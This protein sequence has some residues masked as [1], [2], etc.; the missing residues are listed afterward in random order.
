[1]V[2]AI[3]LAGTHADKSKLIYGQ[4]KAF[5]EI[6]NKPIIL[7]VLQA[8]QNSDYVDKI[9]VVG[10]REKLEKIIDP[11]TIDILDESLAPTES[12]RF[13]ENAV[14][15]Y[16][17]I[18]NKYNKKRIVIAPGDLFCATP[19]IMEKFVLDCN[20]HKASFCFNIIN[21]KNIPP[22]L[23]QFKKSD[24][25]YLKDRKGFFRTGNLVLYD[26][27]D[28]GNEQKE[29][30]EGLIRKA[31]PIRRTN[32][33]TARCRFY[34]FLAWTYPIRT[35]LYLTKRVLNIGPGLTEQGLKKSFKR[36][37]GIS[38]ELIKTRD[39]RAAA[40][41]DDLPELIHF[42]NPENY[43]QLLSR[44]VPYESPQP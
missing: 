29:F 11:N 33:K 27:S 18:K 24:G 28:I 3:I 43:K 6:N 5:H 44:P 2:N 9:A 12:R 25:L 1:M 42:Q 16:N 41:I 31:F 4:N 8:L 26:D 30:T 10:P 23:E 34:A 21:A 35:G 7:N 20:N 39:W 36:K 13:I 37:P 32:S 40:D 14:G 19:E 22:E 15:T 17:F 38:F